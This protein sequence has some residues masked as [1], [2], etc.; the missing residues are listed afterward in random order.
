VQRCPPGAVHNSCV[1]R[2]LSYVRPRA[3]EL[4]NVDRGLWVLLSRRWKPPKRGTVIK[5]P[6]VGAGYG[7]LDRPA[8]SFIQFS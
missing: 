1:M 5:L 7:G 2:H 3:A 4:T 6:V 8:R